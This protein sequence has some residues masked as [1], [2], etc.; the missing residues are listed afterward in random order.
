MHDLLT[1]EEWSALVLSLRVACAAWLGCL[2]FGTATG[3][4]LARRSFP[5][6]G[7]VDAAVHLPLV[8]PPVAVGYLLLLLLGRNSVL[9]SWLTGIGVELAFTWRAAAVASAVMAFP[10]MVRSVRLAIE[11]VD[12]GL[13]AAARTLGASPARVLLTVTLPLAAP[14]L[15]TG[16]ILAFARSLGEF[17]AT[18]TVAG[19]IAGQ[20]RTLPLAMFTYTQL[21]GG[22]E[23]A[24]RLMIISLAISLLSLLA[25]EWILRRAAAHRGSR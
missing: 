22:D 21:P 1:S 13:E 7:L 6:K 25:S 11:L 9:G 12:P 2:A 3:W 23:K 8:L 20:T 5:G 14:G 4:L 18:M 15:V 10:L 24:M 19:N 17:G 16:S